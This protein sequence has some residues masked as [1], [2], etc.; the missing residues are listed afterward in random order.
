MTQSKLR[1]LAL[2][3][4]LILMA[5]PG[6]ADIVASYDV[7]IDTSSVAASHGAIYMQFNPGP[8]SDPA[9]VSITGFQIGAPGVLSSTSFNPVIFP[10]S[11][12]TDGDVTGSLD[13]PP[14]VI[15]NTDG[16]NDYLHFLTFGSW[17]SFHAAFDLPVPLVGTSGSIFSFGLTA[18]DGLSPLLTDDPGGFIGQIEYDYNGVFT[19]ALLSDAGEVAPVPEPASLTLVGI[20]L[21]AG[22]AYI[23]LQLKRRSRRQRS[24]T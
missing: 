4:G 13:S 18:E 11:P 15:L 16:L 23:A 14:L 20:E 17:I 2:A 19:T 8:D 3:A 5:A 24:T 10:S 22:A 12:F 1:F 21:A 7:L 9:S 6:L